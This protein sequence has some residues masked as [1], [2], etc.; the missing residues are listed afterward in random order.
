M[1]CEQNARSN[2]NNTEARLRELSGVAVLFEAFFIAD[3]G[4]TEV[5]LRRSYQVDEIS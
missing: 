5:N 4:F 3:W 1:M 2:F